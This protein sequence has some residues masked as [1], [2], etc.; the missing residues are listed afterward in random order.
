MPGTGDWSPFC[1]S[2]SQGSWQARFI[3]GVGSY[4]ISKVLSVL[5]PAP[6][7]PIHQGGR[8]HL[9]DSVPQ[10]QLL[11]DKGDHPSRLG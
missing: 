7:L 10:W 2:L 11:S 8:D 5:K 3:K 4:A 6:L 9:R 1:K